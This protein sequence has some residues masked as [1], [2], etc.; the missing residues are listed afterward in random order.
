LPTPLHTDEMMDH[1]VESLRKLWA[2]LDISEAA[3]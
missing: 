2:R 3:A 1:L